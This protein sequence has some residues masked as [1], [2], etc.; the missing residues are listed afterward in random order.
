MGVETPRHHT[1]PSLIHF[2][3]QRSV[4][5]W[6][7][8]RSSRHMKH[9]GHFYLFFLLE[10]IQSEYVSKSGITP[11]PSRILP[12]HGL[13]ATF[14]FPCSSVFRRQ[15][16]DQF[17]QKSS[18]RRLRWTWVTPV[19]R[20]SQPGVVITDVIQQGAVQS[21]NTQSNLISTFHW[22]LE[23]SFRVNEKTTRCTGH[24]QASWRTISD[25]KNPWPV[26]CLT[27]SSWATLKGF[28]TGSLRVL[29]L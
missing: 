24:V 5:L 28:F 1:T 13:W 3:L 2:L 7:V 8:H 9:I 25:A 19:I 14:F 12:F 22:R 18:R 26:M 4:H 17:W 6:S 10:F 23:N 27:F 20:A 16:F 21:Y 15:C 29:G 11:G